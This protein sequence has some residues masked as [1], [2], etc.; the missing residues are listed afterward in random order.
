MSGHSAA[1]DESFELFELNAARV[2]RV[3]R[4]KHRVDVLAFD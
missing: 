3:N 1:I 4:I 2:V